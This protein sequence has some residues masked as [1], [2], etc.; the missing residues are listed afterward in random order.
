[1]EDHEILEVLSEQAP[2]KAARALVDM[3]RAR[4]GHDNITLTILEVP[5]G[6]SA[7]SAGCLRSGLILT[8]AGAALLVL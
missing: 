1:V 3:A 5:E 8:A 4:G 7:E 6:D 2:E